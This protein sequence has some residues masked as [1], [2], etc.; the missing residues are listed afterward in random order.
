[1]VTPAPLAGVGEAWSADHRPLGIFV[2]AGPRVRRGRADELSLYDICPTTLALLERPVPSGLDGTV[3]TAA[4]DAR[5]LEAHPVRVVD[6]AGTRS[7]GGG[8]YSD[9][10]AAA[11]ASHLRDLGYLE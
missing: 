7:A 6:P 5:W 8:Q 11:V 2:G 10:E 4:L 1:V 9:E 3:A